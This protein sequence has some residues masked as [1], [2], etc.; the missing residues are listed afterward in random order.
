M[1]I[2]TRERARPRL[3]TQFAWVSGGRIVAALL[4]AVL[5][6]LLARQ[7]GPTDFGYLAA[8]LGL[9][10][11]VQVAID[12][13]VSTLV[14]RERAVDPQSA[15]VVA[16]LRFTRLSAGAMALVIGAGIAAAGALVDP[17]YF[18]MLPLA[19]WAAAER[20][21]DVWLSVAFADGDAHLN[22]LNILG[23][24]AATI[25]G[26]LGLAVLDVEP[27]LAFALASAV[28][29]VVAAG[30]ARLAIRGRVPRDVEPVSIGRV[31]SLARPYW[32]NS[33]ATQARNVDAALVGAIAG[34]TQSG[35]YASGS[36]LTTPLRI[37]PTSL[38]SILIPHSARAG[39]SR[40]AL[41]KTLKI[42][43]ITSGGMAVFYAALAAVVPFAVTP[44][45][46]D[47]YEDAEV[48]IIVVV[49]GL[50]FA[51]AASLFGGVLQ[52]RGM[53][54]SVALGSTTCTVACIVGV[55]ALT[56]A[57]GAVGAAAALS[58][59]YLLQVGTLAFAVRRLQRETP[60]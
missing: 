8:F 4:Q 15:V 54:R 40:V 48:V 59:S 9:V 12:L 60:A 53:A 37:I 31:L 39:A 28:A 24:R 11:L 51:A 21:A 18:A 35:L 25:V 57:F 13:G 43:A 46:G 29:A 41:R 49:L 26:F 30:S 58:T 6:V 32:A 1:T 16:A 10:T 7:L 19:V 33:V 52:G 3:A 45:L 36:R 44:V 5:L 42:A 50:P 55:L 20:N 22:V 47:A 17:V 34:A 27:V 2:G 56:P 23:R 38:A 14:T